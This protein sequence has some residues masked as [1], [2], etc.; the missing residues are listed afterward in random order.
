M[1][2]RPIKTQ[3]QK[4]EYSAVEEPKTVEEMIEINYEELWHLK[5]KK[6]QIS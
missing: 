4:R 5:L 2:Q 3:G 1:G 6:S